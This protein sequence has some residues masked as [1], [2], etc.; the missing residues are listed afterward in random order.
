MA[1]V[2]MPNYTRGWSAASRGAA[3]GNTSGSAGIWALSVNHKRS[4][5]AKWPGLGENE[6]TLGYAPGS[7]GS[8]TDTLRLN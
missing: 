2:A 8:W 4:L 5:K 6:E 1:A 7:A 3:L